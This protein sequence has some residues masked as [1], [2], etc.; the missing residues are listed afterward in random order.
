MA[1]TNGCGTS[2]VEVHNAFDKVNLSDI[3]PFLQS[4]TSDAEDLPIARDDSSFITTLNRYLEQELSR[5]NITE[6]KTPI[7]VRPINDSINKIISA[8]N[9]FVS[10]NNSIKRLGI[11]TY[12]E[13]IILCLKFV[14]TLPDTFQAII[15]H[16]DNFL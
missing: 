6:I 4:Y 9:S 3:I 10:W 8:L 7:G 15:A 5:L 11:I 12:K 14:S 2:P 13:L 1:G 16:L